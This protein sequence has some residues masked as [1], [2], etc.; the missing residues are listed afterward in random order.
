MKVESLYIA[1][2]TS[3]LSL[4]NQNNTSSFICEMWKRCTLGNFTPV[5]SFRFHMQMGLKVQSGGVVWM[6][7]SVWMWSRSCLSCDKREYIYQFSS[8]VTT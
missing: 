8:S 3:Y 4:N 6:G 1:D 2:V 5:I 7:G